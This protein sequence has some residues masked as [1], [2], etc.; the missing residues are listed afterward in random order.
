VWALQAGVLL[1]ESMPS[2]AL[3]AGRA[4]T[5]VQGTDGV[6][7]L[8]GQRR[9]GAAHSVR[10]RMPGRGGVRAS[11][12]QDCACQ[13]PDFGLA[14]GW[15]VCPTCKQGY[16][17]PMQLG[18]AE[19]FWVR[20]Q[21]RPAED[22]QRLSAQNI[23]ANAYLQAGRCAE[24]EP[25]YRDILATDG[26]VHGPTTTT[27]SGLLENLALYSWTRTNTATLRPCSCCLWTKMSS[28]PI[29]SC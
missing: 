5:G 4:H 22:A 9:P 15:Y 7:H 28:K 29:P 24:A 23:L 16:T 14:Q 2:R 19:A 20:L 10:L 17:G 3:E 18:L 1:R 13:A 26:R 8:L 6:L 11:G 21:R 12:V 25:F 27:H